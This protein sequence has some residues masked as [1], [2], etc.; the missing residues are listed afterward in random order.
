MRRP[1]ISKKQQPASAAAPA[2]SSKRAKTSRK[3]RTTGKTK[4]AKVKVAKV[5]TAKVKATKVTND[6]T[7]TRLGSAR[8][9]DPVRD[10]AL[11]GDRAAVAKIKTSRRRGRVSAKDVAWTM[12]QLATTQTSGVPLFRALGMIAS[13]R[14]NS[15]LGDRLEELQRRIGEGA[16]LSQAM[17]EDEKTWG[18]LVI[19]LVGAGEASGSLDRAFTRVASLLMAR[20]ALRRKILGAMTYPVVLIAVTASLVATLLLMVVPMFE[21]IYETL[22][23]E[24]PGLTKAVISASRLALPGLFFLLMLIGMLFFVLRRARTEESLGLKVDSLKMRIPVIG[25][26]LAKGVYSRTASTLAS[27][28][29]SGVPML[30]ALEF[31]AV[32]AGSH[33]HRLSLLNIRRRLTDGG[34]FSTSLAEDG[35]WPDLLLQLATVGEEAGSLP[36]M[37]ERYATRA[38]EEVDAAATAMTKLI[39]P[40][41]IVV[42][43][44][45]IGVFVLALYLPMFN[46]G[47]QLK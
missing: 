33:P 34:T 2:N 42:V 40:L 9:P 22:G 16:S 1:G 43:G 32:A 8:R 10:W 35:L 23:G 44:A 26:L 4:V 29:S 27:L 13:M 21:G 41:L 45:V 14:K 5:K 17:K 36:E 39:E 7:R 31:A 37:M 28:L 25:K 46:L 6:R 47:S 24:L 30:E 18:Q 38:L 19:A 20:M 3:D 12:D 11:S 15:P